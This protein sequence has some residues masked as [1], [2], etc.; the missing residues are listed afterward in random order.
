ML[1]CVGWFSGKDKE[2]S[3]HEEDKEL[4]EKEENKKR[5]LNV[6]FIGHVG[7]FTLGCCF[8][9]DRSTSYKEPQC[10]ELKKW[11]SLF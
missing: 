11:V 3:T 10:S 1:F 5:H 7:K 6:V 8:L 9:F 4:D 2:M